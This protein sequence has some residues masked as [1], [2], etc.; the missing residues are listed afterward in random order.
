V[1]EHTTH[2]RAV[3]GSIP[4]SATIPELVAASGLVPPGFTVLAAVSGGPDSTALLLALLELGRDVVAAHYDHALRAGSETDAEHVAALCGGLG[5]PLVAER[6]HAPLARGSLQTAARAARDDF[7]A[8]AAAEHGRDLIAVAHTGDD[9]GETVVMHLLR[10]TGVAG[11]RGMPA[12]RGAIV[13]P[14]LGASRAQVLEFL[15]ARGQTHLEDPSNADLRFLR[16]RVRHLLMPRLDARLLVRIATSGE[17]LRDRVERQAALDA[18]EPVLRVAALRRLYR[19]AG[20]ADPGLARHHLA[21]MERLAAA[22]RTGAALDLPGGLV[23]RVLPAGVEIAPAPAAATQRPIWRVRERPCAGCSEPGAA[24]LGRGRLSVDRRTPGL[25]LRRP[26]GTRKL[27]DLLVDAKV[28]RHQRD[29]LPLVFLDGRL[30]WVPG[31][32]AD[33]TATTPQALPGRHVW[34]E[35]VGTGR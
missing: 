23:F 8:R 3:A 9:L 2:N 14:L 17:R 4:A 25:R 30:A 20:G 29:S 21:A 34:V 18:G 1:V 16:A 10:G 7:L 6:R 27:Q 31:L 35:G 22:R 15:A 33:V 11:L 28:P 13:R 5:V 24:H 26:A 32:A 19:E 12:R